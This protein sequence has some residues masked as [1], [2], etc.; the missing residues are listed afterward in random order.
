MTKLKKID[1]KDYGFGIADKEEDRNKEY[2]R[3]I[4]KFSEKNKNIR[5]SLLEQGLKIERDYFL[6]LPNLKSNKKSKS[7]SHSKRNK[8]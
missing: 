3:S 6:F 2:K 4:R 8:A 1:L 7:K 5:T